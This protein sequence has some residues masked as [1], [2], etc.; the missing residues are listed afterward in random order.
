VRKSI[1]GAS[2]AANSSQLLLRA[3]EVSY[4]MQTL[5]GL[6]QAL[7][8]AV[9]E[10]LLGAL[11]QKMLAGGKSASECR[12]SLVA[13]MRASQVPMHI[14]PPDKPAQLT[15][16]QTICRQSQLRSFG[17]SRLRM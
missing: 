16:A 9:P 12:P 5:D 4:S 11:E 2:G 1:C 15:K 17:T 7:S 10:F 3:F 6:S 14:H 8:D 13:V